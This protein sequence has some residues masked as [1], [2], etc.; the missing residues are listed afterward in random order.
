MPLKDE[1][2]SGR[3]TSIFQSTQDVTP[4][5]ARIVDLQKERHMSV[6]RRDLVSGLFATP[7]LALLSGR[8]AVAQDAPFPLP[9]TPACA[10]GDALTPSL[11]EGPFYKPKSPLR[12]DLT[13]GEVRG[14]RLRIGGHVVDR[15]CRPIANAIVEL[16]QADGNGQYDN[17]GNRLRGYQRTDAQGRWSF[18]TVLPGQYPGRTRHIHF[19]VQRAGGPILTTQLFF[20]G[21]PENERDRLF[22][23]QLLFDMGSAGSERLG[24]YDFVIA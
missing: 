2:S 16:W 18:T 17:V 8:H 5:S 1:E 15:S 13:G 19:K 11:T 20:P 23:A 22:R 3:R 10:D 7:A 4:C 21:E 24:R 14:M 12:S 9:L 6:T